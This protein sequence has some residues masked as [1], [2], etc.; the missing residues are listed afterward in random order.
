MNYYYFL[1]RFRYGLEFYN[2]ISKSC[3]YLIFN[4]IKGGPLFLE[5]HPNRY[6][7]IGVVVSFDSCCSYFYNFFCYFASNSHLVMDVQETFQEFIQK[8]AI[9]Q[10]KSGS[11]NILLCQMLIFVGIQLEKLQKIFLM[12]LLKNFKAT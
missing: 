6:E 11:K 9:V 2:K 7:M 12:M 3:D 5:T 8:P 1:G 10:H 4:F